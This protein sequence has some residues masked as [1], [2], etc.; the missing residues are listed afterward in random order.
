MIAVWR[1]SRANLRRHLSNRH[2]LLTRAATPHTGHQGGM[3]TVAVFQAYL[4]SFCGWSFL[5]QCRI[6]V[7]L[8]QLYNCLNWQAASSTSPKLK[9]KAAVM[10]RGCAALQRGFPGWPSTPLGYPESLTSC[11]RYIS[12][13]NVAPPQQPPVSGDMWAPHS[14]LPW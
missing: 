8:T 10:S 3:G 9:A 11:R 12:N 6:V 5:L 2:L 13:L 4:E 1:A 14:Q 7:T